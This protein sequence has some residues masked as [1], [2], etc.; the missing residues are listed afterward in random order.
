LVERDVK[1]Y[2]KFK[3]PLLEYIIRWF[4]KHGIAKITLLVGYRWRQ[5]ANYFG[6]GSRWGV[7]ISMS[8]D[9]EEYK[10]T[11][12]ALLNAYKSGLINSENVLVW[13]GDIL[14]PVDLSDLLRKH[15]TSEA[16]ATVV[17]ANKYQVPVGVAEVD[18]DLN[19]VA[20]SEKP[21][22]PLKVSIGILALKTS[23]LSVVEDELGKTFDIMGE[24][25]PWMINKGFKVKAYLYEGT[26]FDIG[27]ME[28]YAKLD[29]NSI[30]EFLK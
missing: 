7:K 28:R 30:A 13:Y 11:G 23:P 19:I 29:H 16:D 15:A 18:E 3:E 4:S 8:L 26:W 14:A 1:K 5:V 25:I 22:L 2:I 21:W 27:S 12:G 17:L 10:G 20:L 6:D 9:T 24:L